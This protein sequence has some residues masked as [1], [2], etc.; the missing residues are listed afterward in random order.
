MDRQR[1]AAI[2]ML[3][4]CAAFVLFTAVNLSKDTED[5]TVTVSESLPQAV[6]ED[7]V[8]DGAGVVNINQADIEELST[9][10]GIGE[11]LAERII[12]FREENGN[13][14]VPSDI[15]DVEGIGEG[16]YMNIRDKICV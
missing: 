13:F 3:A 5:F 14:A 1:A 15:V 2:G 9:L 6:Q 10:P 8:D 16:K 7:I 12:K 4:V 11:V